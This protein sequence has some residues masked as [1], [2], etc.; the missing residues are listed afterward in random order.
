MRKRFDN[1][2]RWFGQLDNEVQCIL[3]SMVE[4]ARASLPSVPFPRPQS[5]DDATEAN[6]NPL[7]RTEPH[8]HSH[9]PLPGTEEEPHDR[10]DQPQ[11]VAQGA[12]ASNYLRRRC[13][14]CF[15]GTFSPHHSA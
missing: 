15:G 9:Q 7:E 2:L 8:D 13:P 12:Y 10:G 4:T 1:A 11:P 14:A 6:S 3:Q 5:R